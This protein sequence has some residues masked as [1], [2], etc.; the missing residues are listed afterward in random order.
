MKTI[1]LWKNASQYK[2][3][4]IQSKIDKSDMEQQVN[5]IEGQEGL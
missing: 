4:G 1:I 5:K 3:H 2:I